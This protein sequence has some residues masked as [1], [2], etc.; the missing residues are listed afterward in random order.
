MRFREAPVQG[1]R[2]RVREIIASSGFFSHE[3]IEVADE[4]VQERLGKGI[5]SGY[6]FLFAEVE[7]RVVGYACYGPIPCTLQSYDLYWIAVEETLRGAGVGRELLRRSEQ[8]M[9]RAGGTRIYVETSSREQYG[10][11]RAFYD[12]CGYGEAAVLEDFYSPGD[13]KVIYLK[14]LPGK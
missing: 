8:A 9:A 6:L 3:E 13:H 2:K 1:D 11:T 5:S 12:A 4:L 7:G 14:V 10:S